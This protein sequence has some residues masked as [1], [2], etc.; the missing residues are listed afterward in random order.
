M[1]SVVRAHLRF[2]VRA[3]YFELAFAAV[4]GRAMKV[5]ATLCGAP[6]VTPLYRCFVD[7]TYRRTNVMYDRLSPFLR[8]WFVRLA[9]PYHVDSVVSLVAWERRGAVLLEFVFVLLQIALFMSQGILLVVTVVGVF[10]NAVPRQFYA[11][12]KVM[13]RGLHI[14]Y[15]DTTAERL[16]D[17]VPRDARAA[18]SYD[19]RPVFDANGRDAPKGYLAFRGNHHSGCWSVVRT[20][21]IDFSF[22]FLGGM[23][24]LYLLAF[25]ALLGL[26]LLGAADRDGREGEWF[27]FWAVT[28]AR[29]A[30][31]ACNFI[32]TENLVN[33]IEAR[34]SQH[35]LY[36]MQRLVVV[37]KQFEEPQRLLEQAAATTDAGCVRE[38][39]AFVGRP[40]LQDRDSPD[41]PL[42]EGAP[43]LAMF[44]FLQ[45]TARTAKQFQST[46]DDSLSCGK[47]DTLNRTDDGK[48]PTPFNTQQDLDDLRGYAERLLWA[49][50]DAEAHGPACAPSAAAG[51][52]LL[53]DCADDSH[54]HGSGHAHGHGRG[55]AGRT[56]SRVALM[57]TADDELDSAV[58]PAT[59][60]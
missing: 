9:G 14:T 27:P 10:L 28:A 8:R 50:F 13:V 32:T 40:C 18:A 56:A 51:E 35:E 26:D 15:I 19:G 48:F 44:K 46:L 4:V 31:S 17:L 33:S 29:F 59:E 55:R 49:V 60:V 21:A 39:F 53:F 37:R 45:R 34:Q 2:V 24:M 20:E 30:K 12:L 36:F 58:M 16:L 7:P 11:Q 1:L 5:V 25:T 22:S 41:S 47:K 42:S 38:R 54:D 6:V 57:E 3:E 43:Q 23:L 52:H